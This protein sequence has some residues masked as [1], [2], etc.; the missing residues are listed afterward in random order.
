MVNSL[1]NIPRFSFREAQ[2]LARESMDT[3]EQKGDEFT[4]FLVTESWLRC[5][6]QHEKWKQSQRIFTEEIERIPKLPYIGSLHRALLLKSG[7]LL[8]WKLRDRKTWRERVSEAINLMMHAG[9][10][11]QLRSLRQDYGQEIDEFIK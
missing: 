5:L 1:V 3:C 2:K 8:A 10:S 11:H 4:F 6:I 7:A 9:L